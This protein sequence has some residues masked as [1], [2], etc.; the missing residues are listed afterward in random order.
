MTDE[1]QGDVLTFISDA[2]K[3]VVEES[4]GISPQEML[5]IATSF[6]EFLMGKGFIKR[7]GIA[8]SL[9][10][11][12]KEPSDIDFIILIE[13]SKAIQYLKDR[14]R[15]GFPRFEREILGISDKW[16]EIF[17]GYVCG[18]DEMQTEIISDNP[19]KVYIKE[20]TIA[21]IDPNYLLNLEK[22]L[23][24]FNQE[25]GVFEKQEVFTSEAKKVMEEAV[26]SELKRKKDDN[27]YYSGL[28]KSYSHQ[29]RVNM[30]RTSYPIT[31]IK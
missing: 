19:S 7:V 26:F 30:A 28:Q 25:K 10:R 15:P 6:A 16:S 12:K 21:N 13:D 14:D 24:I 18:I 20:M 8:G 31:P 9:A 11:G 4:S 22:D 5:R 17:S 27:E 29:K 2:E 23:L 3:K 1:S